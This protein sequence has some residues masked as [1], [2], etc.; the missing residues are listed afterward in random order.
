MGMGGDV[1]NIFGV[2]HILLLIIICFVAVLIAWLLRGISE[3]TLVRLLFALGIALATLELNKQLYMY[4]EV[5]NGRYDWAYFP[6]QLCSVPIYLCLLIPVMG[7]K[8]RSA[9]LTFMA[10][11][12]LL[13]GTAALIFPKDFINAGLPLAV[14]GFVWHGILILISL[15]IIFSHSA[16]LSLKG[17]GRA[18]LLFL[19]CCIIALGINMAVEPLMSQS[20]GFKRNFAAMFYLNPYHISPQPIVDTI[21]KSTSIALGLVLYVCS[22]IAAAGLI[23]AVQKRFD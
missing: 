6:F 11:Y 14:H 8:L 2:L 5:N 1:L 22:I 7:P 19:A 13:S 12:T 21:Q 4:Y 3:K 16:D 15:L 17:F 10:S 9:S 20:I 18:S 23:C